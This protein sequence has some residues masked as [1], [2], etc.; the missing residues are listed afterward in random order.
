MPEL[1]AV[2]EAGRL[3][4][5]RAELA[6]GLATAS[7]SLCDA[8]REEAPGG[9]EAERRGAAGQEGGGAPGAGAL[10]CAASKLH[11]LRAAA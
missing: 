3:A 5:H 11:L 6:L 1:E 9:A 4:E 8:L 7:L 2:S 10:G